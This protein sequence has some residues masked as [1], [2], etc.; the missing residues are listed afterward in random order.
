[1]YDLLIKGGRVIDPAQKID[2]NLDVAIS[3]EKIATVARDISSSEG[4]QVFDARNKLVTP[5]LID[6]HCHVYAG[7]I[8]IAIEPDTIGVKQGVTTLV[9]AG[10]AGEATFAGLPKYIIPSSRTTVFCFLHLCSLGLIPQPELRD[11]SEVNLEAMAATIESHRDLIK[12]IKLRLIGNLVASAGAKV[13]ETAKKMATQYGLPLMI[14]MGDYYKKVSPTLAQ[15]MLPLLEAGDILSH[16]FS[17]KYGNAMRPDGTFIPELF[18]AM[19]R[20][21]VLDTSVGKMNLNFEVAKKGLAQGIMPTTISTDLTTMSLYGPTYS[22]PVT[23]SKFMALGLDLK[24]VIEM[25]T[26][27]P[28]RAISVDDRM[29]SLKPG[30]NAD[31]SVLELQSGRWTL[32][33]AEEQTI[34]GNSLLVPVTTVKA[35]QLIPAELVAMPKPIA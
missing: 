34:E 29:G 17:I 31:V 21:V 9:D 5:G 27:N 14:H 7:V 30:M 6:L 24:Q 2:D 35:G 19:K 22:L 20:G 13:V 1:M 16:F 10:S 26:I 4:K 3:G 18:A 33:D 15:D 12:G 23:M 8:K 28:A 32:E 25:A 11:W